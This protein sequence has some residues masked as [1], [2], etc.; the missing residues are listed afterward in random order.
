MKGPLL[1][2]LL[3]VTLMAVMAIADGPIASS[4]FVGAEDPLS[5]NVASATTR[6]F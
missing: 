5:E 4:S 3:L 2:G 1:G 6:P